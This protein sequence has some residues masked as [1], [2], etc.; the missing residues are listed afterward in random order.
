MSEMRHDWRKDE[1]VALF[2]S[3]INDLLF[4][5]HSVHR[6]HHQPNEVQI[7]TLLRD[8]TPIRLNL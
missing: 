3:P 2:E 7:S 1:V 6:A 5:A 4:D 8:T